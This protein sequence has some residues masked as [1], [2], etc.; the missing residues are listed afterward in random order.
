MQAGINR[1]GKLF[2]DAGC[3]GDFIDTGAVELLQA[4]E[5]FQQVAPALGPYP[6]HILQAGHPAGLA[7]AGAVAGD[8]ETVGLV[9]DLLDQVQGR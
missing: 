2:T 4:A 6:G 8:G 5:M 3:F 1:L 7:A 9:A